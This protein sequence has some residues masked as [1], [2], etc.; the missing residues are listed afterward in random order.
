MGHCSKRQQELLVLKSNEPCC[1]HKDLS[2][3]IR[4][5]RLFEQFKTHVISLWEDISFLQLLCKY[6]HHI[7][8]LADLVLDLDKG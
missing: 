5:A 1:D 3:L 4:F 7:N 2:I 6:S 8:A